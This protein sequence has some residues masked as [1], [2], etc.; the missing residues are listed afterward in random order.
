MSTRRQNHK[1]SALT[2]ATVSVSRCASAAWAFLCVCVCV[3]GVCVCVCAHVLS[4][5]LVSVVCMRVPTSYNMQTYRN[6]HILRTL[7]RHSKGILTL[8][9]SQAQLITKLLAE[10][11]LPLRSLHSLRHPIL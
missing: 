7:R 9:H 3:C 8:T 10:L 11:A 2:P 5:A 6:R 4:C 1:V